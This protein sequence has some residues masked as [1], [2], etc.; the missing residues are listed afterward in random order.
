MKKR[1]ISTLSLNNI[2]WDGPGSFI[3]TIALFLFLLLL[4]VNLSCEEQKKIQPKSK[5]NSPPV[6]ASVNILPEKP[7]RESELSVIIQSNDPDGDPI[8]FRYQWIKNDEDIIGESR[9]TL[10]PGSF[11]KGD[12]IQVRII[13]SDGKVEGK[14]FLSGLVKIVNAPPVI[15]EVWIE[16]KMPTAKE[17]LRALEKSV[18]A[19]GD[20]IYFTYQ[21]EKN[22][23]VLLGEGKE[24]LER[25]QFKKGDTITVTAV[26]DDRE[27]MGTPTKSS[28]VTILNSAPTI[29]SS[30]P[31]SVDGT[32]YIYQV[33]AS[34]PDND[35]ITFNLKSGP[36]GMKIDQGAGLIQWEIRKEDK[37]TH[38]IEIEVRDNEGAISYQRYTLAVEVR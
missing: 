32:K 38:S 12:I 33:K 35:P 20:P 5:A 28:S 15:Q 27:I 1:K 26:P 16:P 19:D 24:I 18:D 2:K 29:D 14:P 36:K 4:L 21:W 3:K 9:N 31:F 23:I 37:G 10:K 13:P 30:P 34:D 25:G 22:G 6:I 8:T 7:N 11:N 17:N